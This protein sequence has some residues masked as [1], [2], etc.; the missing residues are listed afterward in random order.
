MCSAS[1]GYLLSKLC[2]RTDCGSDLHCVSPVCLDPV[3]GGALRT[4]VST[5]VDSSGNACQLN[6]GKQ[7]LGGASLPV[8]V[9]SRQEN[10]SHLSPR[11]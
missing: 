6:L 7:F 3:T 9:R 10:M 1:D 2:C 5:Q 11:F 8:L 4:S